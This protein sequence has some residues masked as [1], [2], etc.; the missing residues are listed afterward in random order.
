MAFD[1]SPMES[2][3]PEAAVARMAPDNAAPPKPAKGM[4]LTRIK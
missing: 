2:K 1:V 3:S 4:H